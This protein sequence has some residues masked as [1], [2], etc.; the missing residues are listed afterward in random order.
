MTVISFKKE[1]KIYGHEQVQQVIDKYL[2]HDGVVYTIDEGCLGYGTLVLT[3]H[4]L[5]TCV[6]QEVYLNEWSS[7]HKIRFYNNMPK[8]WEQKIEKLCYE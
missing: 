6:V 4:N 5:K 3:G 1:P 8:K 2:E 7:G